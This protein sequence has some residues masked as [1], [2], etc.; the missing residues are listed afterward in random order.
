MLSGES[1]MEDV[2]AF[3]GKQPTYIFE[4]IRAFLNAI[5]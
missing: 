4:N 1:T 2:K 5:Q 3:D